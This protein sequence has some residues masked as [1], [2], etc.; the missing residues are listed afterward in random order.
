MRVLLVSHGYPPRETAGTEQHVA[1]LAGALREGGH[2]VHVLAAT[3][4]PGRRAG[5]VFREPGVTRFVNNLTVRPLRQ[6]ER[7]RA[8]EALAREEVHRFRP[9][10][11]HLHHA[12]FLSAGLRFEVPLVFTLH[13]QWAWCA[14]GG[15]GLLPDERLCPGPLPERCAPC[16]A[17]WA[18]TPGR[19][20]TELVRAAG[21]LS[22]WIAPE[23]LHRLYQRLPAR[24]RARVHRGEVGVEPPV[25]A[26]LRNGALLDLLR[27]AAARISPSQHLARLAEAQGS[28]PVDV[29]PHGVAP[30]RPRVG[31]G[32]LLFL[33]TIARHKGPD[34]VVEAWRRAF[35]SGDPPLALHGPVSDARAA[36]GHPI[37]ALLDRDGVAYALSL[38][39]ALVLGSRW[40]ENAPLVVSEARAA[41]CPVI[42]PRIGGLPELILEGRDGLLYPPG[43]VQALSAAL[44]ALVAAPPGPPRPPPDLA[45]SLRATIGVYRRVTGLGA[46][47]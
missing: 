22:P 2:V 42:A 23:R 35:P 21:L 26:A 20:A 29:I 30:G 34:L 13:D 33:G 12:Q 39:S 18:P 46:T 28:G 47:P 10:L 41:G 45:A 40:P 36:L 8:V 31:G 6:A 1:T 25:A 43:D 14:A 37:G 3:R 9:D 38:A 24:L 19:T 5:A 11:V 17:A 27:S 32:P 16:A 4:A 44:R 15:L 7:D